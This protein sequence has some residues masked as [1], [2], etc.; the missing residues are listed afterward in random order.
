M[1]DISVKGDK[2]G[3]M[4]GRLEAMPI[5]ELM[6]RD[7]TLEDKDTTVVGFEKRDCSMD[8][9]ARMKD[10]V[11]SLYNAQKVIVQLVL[12]M[13]EDLRAA[14]GVVKIEVADLSAKLNLPMRARGNQTPTEGVKQFNQ[15]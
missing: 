9:I 4:A 1:N 5:R 11:E 3:K 13:F 7:E 2:I 15:I 12:E 14:F 6:I 10:G 8:S